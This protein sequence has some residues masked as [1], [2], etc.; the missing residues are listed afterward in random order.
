MAPSPV[1]S[2]L[3]ATPPVQSIS[4]HFA[5]R[6]L[7]SSP[8]FKPENGK[9][10]VAATAPAMV[11]VLRAVATTIPDEYAARRR[12]SLFE[13]ARVPSPSS[14]ATAAAAAAWV[15]SDSLSASSSQ[16]ESLSA[17][18]SPSASPAP[19][20]PDCSLQERLDRQL[21]EILERRSRRWGFDF[22]N[23]CPSQEREAAV[24]WQAVSAL[25]RPSLDSMVVYVD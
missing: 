21:A 17:T 1:A 8:R 22:I 16:G 3:H 19:T 6:K 5:A 9:L 12:N 23:D 7:I 4:A 14:M 15:V 11:D 20:T 18:A 24:K 2:A 25:P 13:E 10:A